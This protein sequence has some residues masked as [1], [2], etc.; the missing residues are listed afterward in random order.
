MDRKPDKEIRELSLDDVFVGQKF[1]SDSY[2]LDAERI[3][4]FAREF[5]PQPFHLDE[6]SA[7]TTFFGGLVASGWHTAAI[8]MRLLVKSTPILGGL[9]GAGGEVSWPRAT[10]PGDTLHVESEV[11]EIRPSRSNPQ[12][13]IVT[14]RNIT[15]NQNGQEVQILVSK[16]VVPS[17]NK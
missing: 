1:Q 15:K 7:R 6:E 2:T 11:L 8:T 13:A 9:I 17:R 14:V 5:D 3:K 10:K 16:L 12:R 4:V